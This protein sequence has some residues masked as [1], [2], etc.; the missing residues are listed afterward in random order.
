MSFMNSYKRLDNLCKDQKRGGITG[1]IDE[2]D[3]RYNGAGIVS[4][5]KDDYNNLKTYRHLRNQIAHD[6]YAEEEVLCTE[7]DEIWLDD[8]YQR[9]LDQK[10]PLTLYFKRMNKN[11]EIK[12]TE[13]REQLQ[14]QSAS[15]DKTETKPDSV[16]SSG[17]FKKG[18]TFPEAKSRTTNKGIGIAGLMLL[19]LIVLVGTYCFLL[20][21]Y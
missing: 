10:D 16:Y 18:I 9:I 19:F 13:K 11:N 14:F 5:W 15:L 20:F 12:K 8:F 7:E 17:N 3:S 6:N 1:Y 4:G 2:M 21:Y